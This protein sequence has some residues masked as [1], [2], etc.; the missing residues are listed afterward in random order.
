MKHT[1]PLTT[2]VLEEMENKYSTY[3]VGDVDIDLDKRI[4]ERRHVSPSHSLEDMA[5]YIAEVQP[6]LAER[7]A[8]IEERRLAREAARAERLRPLGEAMG[9]FLRGRLNQGGILRQ[10]LQVTPIQPLEFITMDI[11]LPPEEK[12]DE[13]RVQADQDDS[14]VRRGDCRCAAADAYGRRVGARQN[15]HRAPHLPS[16]PRTR[17]SASR[18][19]GYPRVAPA[20]ATGGCGMKL[21]INVSFDDG[22]ER[23]INRRTYLGKNQ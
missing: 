17:W 16:L 20:E 15:V 2:A 23:L 4:N 18:R 1:R 13:L 12:T 21:C 19:H 7:A 22:K 9:D 11:T 5:R 3:G 8:R 14:A 10:V 6:L